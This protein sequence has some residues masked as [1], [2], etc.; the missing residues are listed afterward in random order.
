MEFP[1]YSDINYKDLDIDSLYQALNSIA[2]EEV[3]LSE[4]MEQE[5]EK[6]QSAVDRCDDLSSE[7]IIDLNSCVEKTLIEMIKQEM[8]LQYKLEKVIEALNCLA[9]DICNKTCEES[10][11]E[12]PTCKE[13]ICEEPILELPICEE[14]VCEEPISELPVCEEP[15]SKEPEFNLAICEEPVCE[16]PIPELP[17]CEEQICEEPV[18]ELLICEKPVCKEPSF[19]PPICKEPECE[20]LIYQQ[21]VYEDPLCILP[22]NESPAAK[23]PSFEHP[24]FE[25]LAATGLEYIKKL[26]DKLMPAVFKKFIPFAAMKAPAELKKDAAAKPLEANKEKYKS[27]IK[28]DIKPEL[29]FE[30]KSWAKPEIKTKVKA[31]NKKYIKPEIKSFIKKEIKTDVKPKAKPKTK[32]DTET[33]LKK[34]AKLCLN[35]RGQGYIWERRDPYYGGIAI[36]QSCLENTH[37]DSHKNGLYYSAHK[38]NRMLNFMTYP[39]YFDVKYQSSGGDTMSIVI[40]GVGQ[41][42]EK[43]RFKSDIERVVDFELTIWPKIPGLC[44]DSF[45]IIISSKYKKDFFH[46]SGIVSASLPLM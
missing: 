35:F 46:N 34:E 30:S 24:A 21:P 13:P 4:T 28:A 32:Q 11:C 23:A 20:T 36:L 40:K 5:A 17:I 10:V 41:L 39:K 31:E 29:E 18:S 27:E 33:K 37:G 15:V 9:Q 38:D 2:F 45:Q 26:S 16:E 22:I 8:L 43:V 1:F 3:C 6:I 12:E 25:V 19:E 14:P 44:I 42:T 7:E